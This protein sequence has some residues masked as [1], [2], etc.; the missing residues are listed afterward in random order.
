MIHEVLGRPLHRIAKYSNIAEG[1]LQ[2]TLSSHPDRGSHACSLRF[3]LLVVVT[4]LT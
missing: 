2:T 1:L 3:L 4:A